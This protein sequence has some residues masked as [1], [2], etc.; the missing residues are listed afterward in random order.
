MLDTLHIN[1]DYYQKKIQRKKQQ[2]ELFA[3]HELG[4]IG[5][6]FGFSATVGSIKELGLFF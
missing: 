2:K 4:L 6:Y 3:A 1:A 5:Q